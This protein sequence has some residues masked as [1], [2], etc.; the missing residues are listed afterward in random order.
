MKTFL[1]QLRELTPEQLEIYKREI[2]KAVEYNFMHVGPPDS[3]SGLK[4]L[5]KMREGDDLHS[6]GV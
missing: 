6:R 1:E 3:E 2:I 5:L 4:L